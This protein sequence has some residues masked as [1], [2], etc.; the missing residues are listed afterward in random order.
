MQVHILNLKW[1]NF[2]LEL[3]SIINTKTKLWII[4]IGRVVATHILV[5]AKSKRIFNQNAN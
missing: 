3:H 4:D 5:P 2:R 1:C